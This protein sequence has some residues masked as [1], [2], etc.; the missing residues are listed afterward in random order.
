MA[1]KQ[2]VE[3]SKNDRRSSKK[4]SRKCNASC[5]VFSTLRK[6][7]KFS[8]GHFLSFSSAGDKSSY[9]GRKLQ[10]HDGG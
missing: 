8:N 3:H 7:R 9:V 6:A 1:T 2:I 10:D 4:V 5:I